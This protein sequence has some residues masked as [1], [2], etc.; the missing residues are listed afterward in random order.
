M[1]KNTR[2]GHWHLQHRCY[3]G[4]L[5]LSFSTHSRILFS[6]GYFHYK[7]FIDEKMLRKIKWQILAARY[8]WCQCPVP[9]RGPAVEKHWSKSPYGEVHGQEKIFFVFKCISSWPHR[10]LN[11]IASADYTAEGQWLLSDRIMNVKWLS[12]LGDSRIEQ[13]LEMRRWFTSRSAATE[14]SVVHLR[15]HQLS[16]CV[17]KFTAVSTSSDSEWVWRFNW[18]RPKRKLLYTAEP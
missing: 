9:G 16:E 13:S 12:L 2:F 10:T 8:N 15:F 18:K 14:V 17:A 4:V 6:S 5:S 3:L 1:F 7:I 11:V